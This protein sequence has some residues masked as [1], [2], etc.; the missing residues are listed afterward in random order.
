MVQILF[1]LCASLFVESDLTSSQLNSVFSGEAV[2]NLI[3]KQK[4]EQSYLSFPWQQIQHERRGINNILP[5]WQRRRHVSSFEVRVVFG[6]VHVAERKRF[7][8]GPIKR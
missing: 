3:R 2:Y 8:C 6:A 1:I 5:L 4:S 7:E